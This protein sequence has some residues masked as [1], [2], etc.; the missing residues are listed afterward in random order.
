[1]VQPILEYSSTVWD[2][3][4]LVNIIKLESI[5]K[6]AARFCYNTYSRFCS[7]SAM[8]NCFC[9]LT[10]QCRRNKAKLSMMYKIIHHLVAIYQII[11]L[12][13]SIP[14]CEED[15]TV[16]WLQG[17]IV[18]NFCFSLQQLNYGT[19]FPLYS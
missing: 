8:Q 9:L 2:P 14:H 7:V 18:T 17:L 16:N 10:L 3:H 19:L 5:Q 4:T 11:V 6:S 12:A 13:L 15:I 1:M